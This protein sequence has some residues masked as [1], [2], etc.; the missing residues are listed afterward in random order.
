MHPR[1]LSLC[2]AVL[3]GFLQVA[4]AQKP[5]V[6]DAK[7]KE[8]E[9]AKNRVA[10]AG[11]RKEAAAKELESAASALDKKNQADIDRILGNAQKPDAK[12]GDVAKQLEEMSKTADPKVKEILSKATEKKPTAPAATPGTTPKPTGLVTFANVPMPSPRVVKN[13]DAE[14]KKSAPDSLIVDSDTLF[15]SQE[16]RIAIFRDNVKMRSKDMDADCQEMEILFKEG[17][18]NEQLAGPPKKDGKAEANDPKATPPPSSEKKTAEPAEKTGQG[19]EKPPAEEEKIEKIWLRGMG[20]I[21]TIIKRSPDGDVICKGRE[22]TYDA[23]SGQL[24][25]KGNPEAEKANGVR[26]V[27]DNAKSVIIIDRAGNLTNNGEGI[28]TELPKGKQK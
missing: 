7:A 22:A 5:A 17:A 14:E 4:S 24:T 18:L 19:G 12:V 11:N 10:Q 20:R 25:L 15:L 23:I 21:V 1:F 6:P 9:A 8:L 28:R 26:L 3:L 16:K 13:A 27:G 2:S